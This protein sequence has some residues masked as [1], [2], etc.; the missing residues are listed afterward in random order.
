MLKLLNHFPQCWTYTTLPA[1]YSFYQHNLISIAFFVWNSNQKYFLRDED[2]FNFNDFSQHLSFQRKGNLKNYLEK[3]FTSFF[4]FN[5][6]SIKE[7][8][9]EPKWPKW[10]PIQKL[11]IT[12][13][14]FVNRCCCCCSWWDIRFVIVAA[15]TAVCLSSLSQQS[16]NGLWL[17]VIGIKNS[18]VFEVDVNLTLNQSVTFSVGVVHKWRHSILDIFWSPSSH[19]HTF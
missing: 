19:H 2:H 4:A 10:L 14:D 8:F 15:A 7:S 18:N 16:Y 9:N 5:S 6:F 12:K 1:R 11:K 13:L 3:H 17:V